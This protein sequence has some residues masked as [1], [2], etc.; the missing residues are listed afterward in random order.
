MDSEEGIRDD[1]SSSLISAIS[2]GFL[3]LPLLALWA[4]SISIPRH[5]DNPAPLAFTYMKIVYPV[6]FL[7]VEPASSIFDKLS[8]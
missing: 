7:C 4:S 3:I 5:D 8:N 2:L 6:A 1:T